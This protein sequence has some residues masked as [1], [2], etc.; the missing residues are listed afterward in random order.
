MERNG[1]GKQ[2]SI[3]ED[4]PAKPSGQKIQKKM[5]ASLIHAFHIQNLGQKPEPNQV[6]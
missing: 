5:H 3:L 4:L 2:E 6:A 1:K